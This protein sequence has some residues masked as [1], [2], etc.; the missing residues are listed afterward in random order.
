M[1]N[2]NFGNFAGNN[3]SNNAGTVK[4]IYDEPITNANYIMLST[5]LTADKWRF[6]GAF[7]T[8]KANETGRAGSKYFNTRSRSYSATA[9]DRDQSATL[10]TEIDLGVALNWDEYTTFALDFGLLMQGDFYKFGGTA[11]NDLGTMF[12]TVA[13]IGVKF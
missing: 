3:N 7:I 9:A 2:Y 6:T 11:T 10:G 12:G 5:A 1:F 8:A 13:S 4:S